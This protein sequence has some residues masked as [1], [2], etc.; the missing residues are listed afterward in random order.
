MKKA[1][2]LGLSIVVA[3]TIK[4]TFANDN[5]ILKKIKA[6]YKEAGEIITKCTHIPEEYKDEFYAICPI[7]HDTLLSN[8]EGGQICGAGTHKITTDFW[9]DIS[10]GDDCDKRRRLIKVLQK[11][12]I[13]SVVYYREYLFDESQNLMFYFQKGGYEKAEIRLY[14]NKNQ[15]IKSLP[16]SLPMQAEEVQ[17]ILQ[18]AENL[19]IKITI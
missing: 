14:F 11:E 17:E 3:L 15:L 12:W 13:G 8:Q 10:A 4:T 5:N 16:E 9:Y 7:Y 19:K 2:Y 6:R 18:G 1:S